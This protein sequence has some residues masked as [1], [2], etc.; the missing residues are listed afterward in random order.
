MC[1]GVWGGG[2]RGLLLQPVQQHPRLLLRHSA[3]RNHS[4]PHTR[5]RR[6]A[7]RPTLQRR[8]RPSLEDLL[9][10]GAVVLVLEVLVLVVVPLLR[11]SAPH[12]RRRRHAARPT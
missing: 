9:L 11:H 6:H 2:H 10:T 3:P 5:R 8:E 1:V 7:A 4:A 12:T